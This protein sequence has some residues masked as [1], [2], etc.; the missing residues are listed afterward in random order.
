MSSGGR[1]SI[2]TWLEGGFKIFTLQGFEYRR[3]KLRIWNCGIENK[4]AGLPQLT[5]GVVQILDGAKPS[6][7][8]RFRGIG[9]YLGNQNVQQVECVI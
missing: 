1:T 9:E 4:T 7:L 8:A 6:F 2:S 3:S 5:G